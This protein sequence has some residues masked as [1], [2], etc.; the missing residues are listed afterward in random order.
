MKLNKI[1]C[2]SALEWNAISLYRYLQ[3][4]LLALQDLL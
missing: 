1:K 4:L 3:F 2:F